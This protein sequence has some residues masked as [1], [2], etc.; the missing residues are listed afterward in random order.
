[1]EL[2]TFLYVITGPSLGMFV[3][4]GGC[5]ALWLARFLV[6]SNSMGQDGMLTS[7]PASGLKQYPPLEPKVG[8]QEIGSCLSQGSEQ[9]F[10]PRQKTTSLGSQ[11]GACFA[12]PVLNPFYLLC[13]TM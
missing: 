7:N 6:P 9:E 3:P 2:L 12:I 4:K 11:W 1:M 13:T 5:G 10:M 8:E